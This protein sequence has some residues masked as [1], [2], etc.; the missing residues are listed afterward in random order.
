MAFAVVCAEAAV[1][2]F[3][4][5]PPV[6]AARRYEP[7]GA[8]PFTQL[9]N[10]PLIYQ[11]NTVFASVYDPT[12]NVRGYFGGDGRGEYTI[13]AYGLR[14]PAVA[15]EKPPGVFR[16]VCLGDSFTFG[17]GVRC[18]DTYPACLGGILATAMPGRQVEVINAGVQAYGTKDAAALLL[19]RCLAFKPDVVTLGF[20]LNDATDPDETIRQ[21]EAATRAY[22]PFWP[23]RVSR[24]W[25][26]G[27]RAI[28]ARRLQEQLFKT[29]RESFQSANWVDCREVLRGLEHVATEDGFRF[30]VVLFP[31][32]WQ[33]DNGYPFED[34]HGL[35]A[36]ACRDAGCEFID[37]LDVYRGRRAE[38]LWVHP[39]DQ[40]PNEIAHQLAARRIAEHLLSP[41]DAGRSPG[42]S[43]TPGM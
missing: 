33:L 35:V 43:P 1:R 28:H 6:Y 13:N 2:L 23:G 37:L 40:H 10:G 38:D 17:E 27:E 12:G 29:T 21:N 31:I 11:P 36:Q 18:A 25:E 20:V 26:I 8:V 3:R 16:V 24:I 7:S 19:M 41:P 4:L 14:G 42:P 32:F 5:G 30:V 22:R 15:Q 39:T 34:L 9:P